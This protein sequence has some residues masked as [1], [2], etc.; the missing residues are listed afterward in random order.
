MECSDCGEEFDDVI[1]VD[2]GENTNECSLE[3]HTCTEVYCPKCW[4]DE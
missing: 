3:N 1:C 2:S 4:E